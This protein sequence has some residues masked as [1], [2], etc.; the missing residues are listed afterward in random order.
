MSKVPFT[1][2]GFKELEMKL[3]AMDDLSL[4]QEAE[5][6]NADYISWVQANVTLNTD[7]VYYL[8]GLDNIFIAQLGSRAAIAFVNRLP[9]NLE[10]PPDYLSLLATDEEGKWFLDK[11]TIIASSIPNGPINATGELIY[12]MQFE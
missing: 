11:S 6:V 9:L 10:L 4:R 2:A 12:E 7:Q 1:P 3:Y 5:D 8:E